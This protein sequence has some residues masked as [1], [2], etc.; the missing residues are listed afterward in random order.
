VR[1]QGRAPYVSTSLAA[2]PGDM[3]RAYGASPG[4]FRKSEFRNSR[5]EAAVG[6]AVG[7]G[8]RHV[9]V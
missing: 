4:D 2:S 6:I 1:S 5:L 9:T 8:G 7:C 3:A